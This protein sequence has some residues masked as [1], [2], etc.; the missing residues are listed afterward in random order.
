MK[1][2]EKAEGVLH[3]YPFLR[4]LKDTKRLN[5]AIRVLESKGNVLKD[6][7]KKMMH[8]LPDSS[9][10]SLWDVDSFTSLYSFIKKVFPYYV[11]E[12]KPKNPERILGFMNYVLQSLDSFAEGYGVQKFSFSFTRQEQNE[13]WHLSISD[14][15]ESVVTVTE[16]GYLY[17]PGMEATALQTGCGAFGPAEKKM[18]AYI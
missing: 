5:N 16:G 18:A 7:Y 9:G 10:A 1:L 4:Y 12:A 3:A 2:S 17:T 14:D 13:T 15:G 6:N 8:A 11:S